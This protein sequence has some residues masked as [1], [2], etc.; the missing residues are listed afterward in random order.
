MTTTA[1]KPEFPWSEID[2]VIG[3]I[4]GLGRVL[5]MM[6][7]DHTKTMRGESAGITL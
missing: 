4:Q 3:D 5:E 7:N 2:D 1:A 6:G